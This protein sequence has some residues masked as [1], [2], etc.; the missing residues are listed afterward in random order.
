MNINTYLFLYRVHPLSGFLEN[1]FC[2]SCTHKP[3]THF[4]D[5]NERIHFRLILESF[6]VFFSLHNYNVYVHIRMP[7]SSKQLMLHIFKHSIFHQRR[8][9]F[10]SKHL[11]QRRT[12]RILQRFNCYGITFTKC[13]N[14]KFHLK[15]RE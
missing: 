8:Y 6:F 15:S 4:D 10:P 9:H 12:F 5:N 11:V 14:L 3:N 13:I 7:L 2:V 1:G